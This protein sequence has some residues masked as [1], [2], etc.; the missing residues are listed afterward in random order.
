MTATP[1]TLAPITIGSTTIGVT[2]IGF[3]HDIIANVSIHSGNEYPTLVTVPGAN[4]RV[5]FRAHFQDIYALTG[6]TIL[7]ASIFSVYLAKYSALIKDSG[8]VH[9]KLALA[10]SAT[11]AIQITSVNTDQDGLLMADCEAYLLS[12]D[13]TTH[14]TAQTNNNALPALTAAPII[15]T[16][17]PFVLNSTGIPGVTSASIS[18]GQKY[19]SFRGDGDNYP[20][21]GRR[22]GGEPRVSVEHGDPVGVL[23]GLG[24]TGA[25][26][27]ANAVQ[28]F[29]R[30]DA[31]TGVVG[32][33]NGVSVT[34]ASGRVHPVEIRG[35]QGSIARHGMEVIGLSSSSTHPMVIATNASVPA[36][37]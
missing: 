23:T 27:T 37:G 34:I 1:Y 15:H 3:S 22:L 31:T 21:N 13:G 29:R 32:S 28:Y 30:Y 7:S 5:T 19:E 9:T 6:L 2:Q 16:L 35:E 4:P 10:T 36:S 24:L 11:A 25:N 12:A 26:I 14:P 33:S 8:S 17:G 18:L 20:K